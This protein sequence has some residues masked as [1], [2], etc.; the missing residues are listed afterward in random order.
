MHQSTLHQERQTYDRIT[1]VLHWSIAIGIV[2]LAGIELVR[3]ELPKG[4]FFREGLKP[5]H[6]PAG[7][8]LFGLIL[9][10]IMWR[11][12]FARV[13]AEAGGALAQ[14]LGRLMHLVLHG[15]MIAIPLL[16]ML[17]VF[18][19]GKSINLGL[20]QLVVPLQEPLGFA[21]KLLREWHE[22][23][24]IAILFVAGLHALAALFHHYVLRDDTLVRMT[25]GRIPHEAGSGWAAG[26]GHRDLAGSPP[27]PR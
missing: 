18:A 7:T 5:I 11:A 4:S 13:P 14:V 6:Q 21:A 3:H 9:L 15:L 12:F 20:V 27:G 2:L 22:V 10:R 1:M 25:G 8:V 16:G 24:G 26:G 19:A 23:L 17:S